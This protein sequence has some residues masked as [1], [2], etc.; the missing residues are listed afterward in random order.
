MA[1]HPKPIQSIRDYWLRK[2]AIY[3]GAA[4]GVIA[5]ATLW[6][7]IGLGRPAW[8]TDVELLNNHQ[9]TIAV[10]VY[11]AKLRRYL[12]TAAPTDPAAKQIWDEDLRQARKQRDDAEKRKIE[13]SK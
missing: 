11:D 13:L 3:G 1:K 5:I 8:S 12:S 9:A 7:M 4:G 6:T 2:I 10:E